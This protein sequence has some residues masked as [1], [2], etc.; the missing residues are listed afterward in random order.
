MP[1][2]LTNN[3]DNQLLKSLQ[4]LQKKKSINELLKESNIILQEKP[5]KVLLILLDVS[6]SMISLMENASK[7]EVAWGVLHQDLAPNMAGWTYGIIKF[8]DGAR[9]EIAPT[10]NPNAMSA[11]QR[12]HIEGNTDLVAGLQL[13]W[14]WIRH[15]TKQARIIVLT[16]GEPTDAPKNAILEMVSQHSNIPIDTIGIGK[17][18]FGYDPIFL[19]ELSRITGGIFAEAGSVAILSDIIKALS[20]VNRPLLGTV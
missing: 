17:G 13:S 20:P 7:L 16:D 15:N 19:A 3:N 8:S 10:N 12:P 5:D 14:E 4:G 11:V 1:N 18:G 2:E 9:F 6:G